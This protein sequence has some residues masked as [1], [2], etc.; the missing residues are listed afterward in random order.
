V[1]GAYNYLRRFPGASEVRRFLVRRLDQLINCCGEPDWRERFGGFDWPV[2]AQSL[3]VAARILDSDE[4]RARTDD[5]LRE[6]RQVTAEGT[7][8]HRPGDNPVE[9]ELPT[10]AAAFIEAL[11]AVFYA[12]RDEA[13]LG[14]IRSAT[15]WFLGVN[16]IGESLYDFATGGCH[17]ALT[18]A[19][20]NLNQG[21]EATACCL[22]AFLTLHRMAGLD[23]AVSI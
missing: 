23:T 16:R 9:E 1:L 3:T 8:F 13:L 2:A 20:L 17:D 14:P 7:V 18:A 22:L 15:D 4:I 21:T 10:T 19:G 12:G 6:V 11:G 5:C